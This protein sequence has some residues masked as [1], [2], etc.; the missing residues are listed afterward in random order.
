M[1]YRDRPNWDEGNTNDNCNK[2]MNKYKINHNLNFQ[3]IKKNVVLFL[4]IT[5]VAGGAK[6]YTNK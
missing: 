2:S 3:I 1:K 4:T 5:V 6:K